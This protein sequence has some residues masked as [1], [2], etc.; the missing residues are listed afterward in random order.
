MLRHNVTLEKY[1]LFV[2]LVNDLSTTEMGHEILITVVFLI[3]Y[4][5]KFSV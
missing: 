1:L 3:F 4:A 5:E 2:V